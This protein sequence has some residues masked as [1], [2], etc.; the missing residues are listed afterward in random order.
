MEKMD[1]YELDDII[2]N[3]AFEVF[4]NNNNWIRYGDLCVFTLAK[5]KTIDP[6]IPMETVEK[7]IKGCIDA[8]Y[9]SVAK[10]APALAR[11]INQNATIAAD[12]YC[13]GE[14]LGL[15]KDRRDIEIDRNS[16]IEE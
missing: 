1:K 6:D 2:F 15:D 10:L 5:C 16:R 13:R 7:W 12:D 11:L 3:A 4:Y 8:E 14:W 9:I